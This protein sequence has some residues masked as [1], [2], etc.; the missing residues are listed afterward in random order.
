[1]SNESLSLPVNPGNIGGINIL[2]GAD[3]VSIVGTRVGIPLTGA[4]T[5]TSAALN[6]IAI[7]CH[8]RVASVGTTAAN[9]T[10]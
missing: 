9:Q 3:N 2:V 5:I 4:D 1:M 8:T 10:Y 7:G 6:T